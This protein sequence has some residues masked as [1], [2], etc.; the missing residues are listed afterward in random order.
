MHDKEPQKDF[1]VIWSQAKM[2]WSHCCNLNMQDVE[3][4]SEKIQLP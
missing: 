4:E 2:F 3:S 1:S